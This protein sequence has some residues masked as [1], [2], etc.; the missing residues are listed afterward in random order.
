MVISASKQASSG[1]AN[2]NRGQFGT[3]RALCVRGDRVLVGGRGVGRASGGQRACTKW[4]CVAKDD[5]FDAAVNVK[6]VQGQSRSVGRRQVNLRQEGAGRVSSK[7][8]RQP[9]TCNYAAAMECRPG[10]VLGARALCS[11]QLASVW[12]CF[13]VEN[14]KSW[15]SSDLSKAKFANIVCFNPRACLLLDVLAFRYSQSLSTL[16]LQDSRLDA[17]TRR[18][19]SARLLAACS[20]NFP[21]RIRHARQ[22]SE[23]CASHSRSVVQS[24]IEEPLQQ[25]TVMSIVSS[26][27]S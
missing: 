3:R 13:S 11:L 21:S 12:T 16:Q 23:L 6:W 15:A 7:S 1:V 20:S 9:A 10:G 24:F 4:L 25:F 19:L 27:L 8:G 22:V 2:S 26:I 18:V 17:T 14:L 5:R